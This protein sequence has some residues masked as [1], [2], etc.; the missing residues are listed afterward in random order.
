MSGLS[1]CTNMKHGKLLAAKTGS[2]NAE[3]PSP[4]LEA[5][6]AGTYANM[7][8]AWDTKDS[9]YMSEQLLPVF[10]KNVLPSRRY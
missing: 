8:Q 7:C 1:T 3:E 4:T 2:E 6:T 9:L 5:R 10:P